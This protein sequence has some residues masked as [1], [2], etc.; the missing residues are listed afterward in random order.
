MPINIIG[1]PSQS[2][3]DSLRIIYVD[4]YLTLLDHDLHLS[5]TGIH[6]RKA[7]DETFPHTKLCAT[8]QFDM[9]IPC[10]C[11]AEARYRL[12][13]PEFPSLTRGVTRPEQ[14][15]GGT[16]TGR[17]GSLY[18]STVPVTVVGFSVLVVLGLLLFGAYVG[19]W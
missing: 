12:D 7:I 1:D 3:W 13:H 18:R 2:D 15:A 14:P 11:D 16:G 6:Y 9:G 19:W 17:H 8:K 5:D 4:K 10:T